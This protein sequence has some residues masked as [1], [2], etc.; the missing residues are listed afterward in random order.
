MSLLR[1]PLLQ[2]ECFY[3]EQ[4]GYRSYIWSVVPYTFHF[5]SSALYRA[6]HVA[7]ALLLALGHLYVHVYMYKILFTYRLTH[8][9]TH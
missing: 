1:H 9:S 8:W 2:G 3:G 7:T 6:G 5:A 4:H